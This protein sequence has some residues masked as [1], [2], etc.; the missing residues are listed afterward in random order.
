M[1]INAYDYF[2]FILGE[3]DLIF[4]QDKNSHTPCSRQSG[5][6]GKC[7]LQKKM[8]CQWHVTYPAGLGPNTAHSALE[9]G[10]GG[11]G[12]GAAGAAVS[13][14]SSSQEFKVCGDA[15]RQLWIAGMGIGL[16]CNGRNSDE[17][18]SGTLQV[19]IWLLLVDF[20]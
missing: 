7:H 12:G 2:G 3:N 16:G 1:R 10:G 6:P 8:V 4:E 15:H 20:D 5:V 18:R 17:K 9:G 19:V 14:I 11:R 13:S